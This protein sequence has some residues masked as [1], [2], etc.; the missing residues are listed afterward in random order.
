ME[1][2]TMTWAGLYPTQTRPL[3]HLPGNGL[4]QLSALALEAEALTNGYG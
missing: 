3:A 4:S 1:T 2:S